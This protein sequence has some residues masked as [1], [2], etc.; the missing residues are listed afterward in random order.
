MT[1]I[2]DIASRGYGVIISNQAAIAN[3]GQYICGNYIEPSSNSNAKG[4]R[5]ETK[6][7][8][9]TGNYFDMPSGNEIEW[10]SADIQD[11]NI[12]LGNINP[13][14]IANYMV[15]YMVQCI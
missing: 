13:C 4:V 8:T 3:S 6:G 15:Y 9:I 7:N 1:N 5:I 12:I 14:N 11:G 10:A 2:G